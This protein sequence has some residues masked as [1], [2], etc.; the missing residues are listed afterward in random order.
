LRF[1]VQSVQTLQTD[2]NV[3]TENAAAF[4]IMLVS[5]PAKY[6]LQ[7]FAADIGLC[8]FL[9]SLRFLSLTNSSLHS[10]LQRLHT[11]HV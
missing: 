5:F 8:S 4:T 3:D 6:F 2:G 1:T 11:L 10:V 9:S 7:A